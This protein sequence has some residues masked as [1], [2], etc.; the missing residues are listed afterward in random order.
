MTKLWAVQFKAECS[1]GDNLIPI[2]EI[3]VN[4]D[5]PK[6]AQSKAEKWFRKQNPCTSPIPAE[7]Q[8]ITDVLLLSEIGVYNHKKFLYVERDVDST[9]PGRL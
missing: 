3:I 4:A 8:Q 9:R 5:S 6:G 1:H 7:I 2:H